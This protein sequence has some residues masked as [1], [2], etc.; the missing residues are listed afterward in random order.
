MQP[1][2]GAIPS[3][4]QP[5]Q[6][7]TAEMRSEHFVDIR[8]VS[9]SYGAIA[10]LH[11]VSLAV[12]H[13]EFLTLL[14]PSGCGKTTLLY[15]V[16]GFVMPD[17]GEIYI[18]GN[19]ATMLPPRRRD[20][21]VVFQNYA[22]FPHMTVAQNVAFGLKMRH[23]G[24]TEER[25][26]V[27]QVL[28]VVRLSG[29]EQRL[30]RELSGG[31]QQRVALARALVIEPRVLL[32]DESLSALD[33]HLRLEMQRELREIHRR[34]GV[35][36]IFVTHDQGEALTLSD[37]IAVMSQ[38]VVQQV[39]TPMDVYR[40]PSNG[41]VASFI[42]EISM[43]PGR[44]V[45]AGEGRVAVAIG[46]GVPVVLSPSQ[47]EGL[48]PGQNVSLLLR[49]EAITP[50]PDSRLAF[51]HGQVLAHVYQGSFVDIYCSA[52]TARGAAS[53]HLRL[54]GPDGII[55]YPVGSTIPLTAA[56]EDL[57]VLPA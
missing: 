14:G 30:P 53:V 22:L 1:R 37:R 43:L 34:I 21:G 5:K 10:A 27:A 38:G 39:G 51:L 44:V 11:D 57:I 56:P 19:R 55:H 3:M 42:G 16:G 26:R 49:P 17:R 36:T 4:T 41:F 50:A 47:A 25:R 7:D 33:K 54:L 29:M 6:E 35:T 20:I 28:D 40:H 8:S 48:A 31:Q 32:L 2:P 23:V 18:G 13:G 12:R 24:Q 9:K 52:E 15:L 45:G 46:Q